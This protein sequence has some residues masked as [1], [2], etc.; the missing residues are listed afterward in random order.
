MSFS[1][2]IGRSLLS[3]TFISGGIGELQNADKLAPA[4][5]AAREK[6]P[7]GLREAAGQVDSETLVKLDGIVM[8]AA[9]AGVALGILPRLSAAV[10]AAQMV[11]VTVVGHRFW[12]KEGE[13]RQG[14]KIHFFKN[15]SLAGGLLLIALG[16]HS[17]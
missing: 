13:E 6:L 17:K 2:F 15:A 9:G 1:R 14:N 7:A 4:L 11:P 16:G 10:L 5:D 3:T 12:E 8:A